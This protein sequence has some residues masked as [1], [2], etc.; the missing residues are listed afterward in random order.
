MEDFLFY[1]PNLSYLSVKYHDVKITISFTPL[2]ELIKEEEDIMVKPAIVY[3]R[4]F[5]NMVQ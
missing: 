2:S 1:R 3:G 4:T 5:T